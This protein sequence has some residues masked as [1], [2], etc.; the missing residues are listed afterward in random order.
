MCNGDEDELKAEIRFYTRFPCKLE[1]P[2]MD[3]FHRSKAKLDVKCNKEKREG[4]QGGS[5]GEGRPED[6]SSLNGEERTK[7][8][9]LS[10]GL[11][12]CVT[13]DILFPHIHI[14]TYTHIMHTHIYL[15][16]HTDT[17]TPTYLHTCTHTSCTHTHRH[18]TF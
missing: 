15:Y 7:S 16:T 4:Q 10:S 13:A 1:N 11:Q 17:H 8:R 5:V 2:V 6:V 3:F 14:H 12:T 9:K 18:L